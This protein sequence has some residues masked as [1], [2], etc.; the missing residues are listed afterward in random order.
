MSHHDHCPHCR[1]TLPP[2]RSRLLGALLVGTAWIIAMAMVWG[3]VLLGPAVIAILP[4][5]FAGGM[6]IITVAHSWAFADRICDACG[7]LVEA[8]AAAAPVRRLTTA[9][10]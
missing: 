1:A 10:A 9:R 3:G 5:L 7:K 6:S 4:L 8:P 2:P